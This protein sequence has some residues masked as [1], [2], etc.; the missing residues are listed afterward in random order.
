MGLIKRK[1]ALKQFARAQENVEEES[2]QRALRF[3]DTRGVVLRTAEAEL[4]AAI[5][6]QRARPTP[7]RDLR[8]AEARRAFEEARRTL[9][10]ARKQA[11]A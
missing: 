3:V 6:E 1:N 8:V 10:E 7:E 4:R 5:A 9:E 11:A 2:R